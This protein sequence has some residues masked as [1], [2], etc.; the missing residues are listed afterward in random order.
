M[1]AGTAYEFAEMVHHRYTISR[2]VCV[3]C[4]FLGTLFSAMPVLY[5]AFTGNEYPKDC[6]IGLVGWATVGVGFGFVI[7]VLDAM[8]NYRATSSDI[9]ARLAQGTLVLSYCVLLSHFLICIRLSPTDYSGL[10]NM[11]GFVMTVKMSDAGAY[12]TGRAFGRR[13]LDPVISPKKTWE[14]AIGGVVVSVMIA[15]LFFLVLKEKVFACETTKSIP[16]WGPLVA[17]TLIAITGLIGDLL[18]SV[19][20][21]SCG[22]KD[23]SRLLPG[24]GGIWDVT[25]SLFFAA[26]AGYLAILAGWIG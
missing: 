18:E 25:D 24:L 5:V 10:I 8:R 14:G 16:W 6:P 22:V 7:L 23:S 20:K 21:R 13:P 4:V 19:V 11:V 26:P 17:G 12:F 15:A 3:G 2:R 9:T 1:V